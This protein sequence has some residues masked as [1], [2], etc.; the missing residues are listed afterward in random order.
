MPP[1]DTTPLAAQDG[2]FELLQVGF[3][4]EAEVVGSNPSTVSDSKYSAGEAAEVGDLTDDISFDFSTDYD[5]PAANVGFQIRVDATGGSNPPFDLLI[6][7]ETVGSVF[8][9]ALTDGVSWFGVLGLGQTLSAGSHTAELDANGTGS[10]PMEVD[11]L[12]VYDDRYNYF[13]DNTTGPNGYLAGPQLYPEQIAYDLDPEELSQPAT[14][15]TV[16]QTWNETFDNQYVEISLGDATTREDNSDTATVSVARENAAKEV[17]VS[18]RL[19]R[20]GNRETESPRFG[21]AG[22]TIDDHTISVDPAAIVKRGIGR[23]R[24]TV[25]TQPGALSAYS[26][27]LTEAGTLDGNDNLLTRGIYSPF[28]IPDTMRISTNELVEFAGD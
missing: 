15:A 26:E 28:P 9:D 1:A 7:G 19:S 17:S 23:A 21:F 25:I 24:T 11:A 6:D 20:R 10:G 3:F 18:V 12:F 4:R 22:Q 2:V 13:F 8:D 16:E 14:S 27:G 5:I